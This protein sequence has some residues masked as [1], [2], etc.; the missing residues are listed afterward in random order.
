MAVVLWV[1]FGLLL[2]TLGVGFAISLIS[3]RREVDDAVRMLR[4]R[5]ER[6]GKR[7]E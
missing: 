1:G 3:A 7:D 4:E 6:E 5:R 2:A